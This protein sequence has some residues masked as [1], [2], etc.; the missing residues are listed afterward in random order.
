[1]FRVRLLFEGLAVGIFTGV[2]VT[3]IRILLDAADIMR[4]HWFQHLSA[5]KFFV[6]VCAVICVAK[7]LARAIEFDRQVAGSGVPQ[8]K[9]IL[10][11]VATMTEPLRL[12]VLKFTA[13]VL[14]IGAGMSL[15][16]AG[17]SV[18]FGACVGN[19][20][21]KIFHRGHSEIERGILLTAGAG[22]GLAAIFNAPLA[23]IIFCVEELHR[24]FTP[25]VL[26][27]TLTAAVSAS[28]VVNLVFGVQPIFAEISAIPAV[29][30][31][32]LNVLHFVA[33]GIFLGVVG[34]IFT[35][36]MIL[37]LD[38]YDRLEIFGTRRFLIPLALTIPLGVT[39]PEVLGCG[40]VLVNEILSE[41]FVLGA[42]L[43]FFAGKFLFTLISF[44]T[45]APGG[46]F[47]PLLTL[48]ALGGSIY[49]D[50]GVALGLFGAEWSTLLIIF[51][52]AAMFAA[53]VKAPVTGSILIMEITGQFSYL[54][55]LTV[56]AG[57]AFMTA[58]LLGGE[59][60][61]SALLNR[62]PKS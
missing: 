58:D 14:A 33:L 21:G 26:V 2:V 45:G 40:N 32:F 9:G 43:I 56:V 28:A 13:T 54:L 39:L 42:T 44:G 53:V 20:F 3:A 60:I 7:F 31:E 23:G 35:R 52:M 62:K 55:M 29:V 51:G 61:F 37:A 57:A 10:Q 34:V 5:V 24:K 25:E 6:T 46:V 18:Q 1:M 48:G 30:P 59:P 38:V 17:V 4:P 27:A 8:I 11:G 36:T 49:A 16:R 19:F 12:I 50:I 15:G 47:L 41:E 22:A